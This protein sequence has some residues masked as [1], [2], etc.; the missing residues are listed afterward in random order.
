MSDSLDFK[1]RIKTVLTSAD[2]RRQYQKLKTELQELCDDLSESGAFDLNNVLIYA[3][4]WAARHPPDDAAGTPI[5]RLPAAPEEAPDGA[6]QATLTRRSEKV[7]I[8]AKAEKA[9]R[10]IRR[11]IE[12]GLGSVLRRIQLPGTGLRTLA[13]WE[14]MERAEDLC[15]PTHEDIAALETDL[16]KWDYSFDFDTNIANLS[17]T[18]YLLNERGLCTQEYE[19]IKAF[20]KATAGNLDIDTVR[21]RYHTAH[22]DESARTFQTMVNFYTQQLPSV[23]LAAARHAQA[24]HAVAASTELAALRKENAALKATATAAAAAAAHGTA[25]TPTATATGGGGRG[26]HQPGRGGGGRGGGRGGR[27]QQGRGSS[28][29]PPF[30]FAHGYRDHSGTICTKMMADKTFTQEMNDA[31]GPCFLPDANRKMCPSKY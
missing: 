26:N 2:F 24:Q 21:G 17:D 7:R 11:A 27:T 18:I 4:A 9:E 29:L 6:S 16:T 13:T 3:A 28:A 19:K 25:S 31:T 30:C 14:I 15:R 12:Y 8:A 20:D 5:P 23:F 1:L 10:I 22:G